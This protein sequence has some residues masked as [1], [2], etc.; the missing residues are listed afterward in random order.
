M[1][2]KTKKF[3]IHPSS[4]IFFVILSLSGA[5]YEGLITF[6]CALL[7][8][9]GHIAGA[10]ICRARI[11][12]LTVYPFGADMVLSPPLRSYGSDIIISLSGPAVNLMLFVLGLYLGGGGFFT[13]CNLAL[14]TLNLLP[15]KG[16]DGGAVLQA[17]LSALLSPRAAELM[18]T[19]FSFSLLFFA[20][21]LSAYIMLSENGDPSLFVIT[22]ALFASTF[23]RDGYGKK[24][25]HNG[26]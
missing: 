20:W 21:M 10:K 2:K 23:L 16:L 8:E 17:L 6:I 1:L 14:M 15:V 19:L 11:A 13:A 18:L 12:R 24:T 22:A 3:I 5:G 4:V 7:H 25:E 26:G 9:L